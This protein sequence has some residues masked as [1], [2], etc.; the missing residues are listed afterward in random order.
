[1]FSKLNLYIVALSSFLMTTLVW[2]QSVQDSTDL[3][4]MQES[5]FKAVESARPATILTKENIKDTFKGLKT[6]I[7]NSGDYSV[8]DEDLRYEVIEHSGNLAIRRYIP[9]KTCDKY[10]N[11]TGKDICENNNKTLGRRTSIACVIPEGTKSCKS[12]DGGRYELTLSGLLASEGYVRC[13]YIAISPGSQVLRCG[14]DSY[15]QKV[16]MWNALVSGQ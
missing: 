14:Y 5:D 3:T 11:P 13:R 9:L 15:P 7:D 12:S 6:T 4:K 2:S 1:M 10:L 8:Y 16:Y